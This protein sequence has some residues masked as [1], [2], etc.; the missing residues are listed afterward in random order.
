MR[1]EI[2]MLSIGPYSLSSCL[3]VAPMAGITDYP[4]RKLCRRYGAAMATS[5]MVTSDISLWTSNKSKTRLPTKEETEPRSVQIAGSDPEMMGLAAQ[6]NV[7]LGAQIIDINMG[8]PAKKVCN[9][10]AGSALL[11]DTRLVDEILRSVVSAVDVPVTLKFRTGWSPTTRNAIEI[12]QIAQDAGIASL[13]LHGRTR[14][15]AY[16]GHAEYETIRHVK[17]NVS[18]PVI[19]NGDI[20]TPMDAAF[21]LEYTHA[22]GV[23]IGRGAFGQ[24]WIFREIKYLLENSAFIEPIDLQEKTSVILEHI[25]DIHSLFGTDAGVRIARKHIGWYLD[26]VTTNTEYKKRIFAI[27]CSKQQLA[28]VQQTFLTIALGK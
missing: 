26:R 5:E 18:L 20:Q 14:A 11:R 13:A 2:M 17:Q 6:K 12:A 8:C 24:P 21:I 19:A 10:A 1:L 15:D 25:T 7:Q 16:K 28:A 27:T 23:M 4:F 3:L 22:D 9:K